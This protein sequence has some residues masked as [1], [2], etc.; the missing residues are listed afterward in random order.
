MPN[1]YRT[2]TETTGPV[3][4]TTAGLW[5]FAPPASHILLTN[6]SGQI[7]YVRFN[8]ATAASVAAHDLS[9]ADGVSINIWGK[10][11]GVDQMEQ[12]GVW[13]PAASTPA[14]FT[15]RGI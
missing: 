1:E 3:A 5:T 13:F 6:R 7:I 15:I 11:Y 10:E 4:D 14:N 9:I 8:T 12:I 2:P